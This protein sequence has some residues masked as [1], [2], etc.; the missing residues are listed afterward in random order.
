MKITFI[1]PPLNMSGGI[2]VVGIYAKAFS[3]RGHKVVL[4]SPAHPNITLKQRCKALIKEFKWLSTPARYP[5]HID[6][7][8]IENIILSENR[9]VLNDDIPDADVVIATW[10]ET[11]EWVNQ[12]NPSKGE[13][14]YFIQHHE[15][16]SYF[17]I[18]RVKATYRLPLKKIVIAKWLKDLMK[19]QYADDSAVLINNAVDHSQ[20]SSEPR[21]KQS[22]P[23]VGFLYA[24]IPFKGTDITLKA[25][26]ILRERYSNLRIISFGI[27]E[28]N[29]DLFPDVEFYYS[30]PQD[31][32]RDLYALCD[33]WLTASRSEGF[34]LPAMEA[35]ACRTPVVSTRTG[36]PEEAIIAA[37]N[38][39]LVDI[40]DFQELAKAAQSI[41][42]MTNEH[43]K[44]MSEN[45]HATVASCSWEKSILQFEDV[46]ATAIKSGIDS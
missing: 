37:E 2:K 34:N 41:L 21:D 44:T 28:W 43:W 7:L 32:I 33:V 27:Y 13:K 25:L 16:F 42:S 14:F 24:P 31:K 4:V 26:A 23:T 3:E 19:N 30:P 11:A 17:S 35:M 20:F 8:N 39:F 6:G 18:E 38:G 1:L 5:S 36:W 22:S 45:A 46:L 15:I 10:W 40:D 29:R 12:F 9:P